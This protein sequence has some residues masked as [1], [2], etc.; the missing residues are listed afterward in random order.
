MGS[1]VRYCALQLHSK[2]QVH[3]HRPQHRPQTV[4]HDTGKWSTQ[5]SKTSGCA[6]LLITHSFRTLSSC[7]NP[8]F[9]KSLGVVQSMLPLPFI[10]AGFLKVV[11]TASCG[12][13]NETW[14]RELFVLDHKSLRSASHLET[15][16]STAATG[17]AEH[18][19]VHFFCRVCKGVPQFFSRQS[20]LTPHL[21]W[22]PFLGSSLK[23]SRDTQMR[24]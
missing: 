16:L 4:K 9:R 7:L 22:V 21:F 19:P 12:G 11:E 14:H 23:L 8:S 1:P 17:E 13:P 3:H 2:V 24:H 15:S 5:L 20:G 6:T 10:R 18:P